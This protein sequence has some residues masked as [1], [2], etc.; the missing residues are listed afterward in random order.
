[1]L[2]SMPKI[3]MT[4][5]GVAGRTLA[6]SIVR[7]S[8]GFVL[9]S[10]AVQVGGHVGGMRFAIDFPSI[11]TFVGLIVLLLGLA[12]GRRQANRGS[13]TMRFAALAEERSIER[14]RIATRARAALHDTVLNDLHA[15]TLSDVGTLT[16]AHRA[17]LARDIA[18]LT[19]PALLLNEATLRARAGGDAVLSSGLGPVIR[20]ARQRGLVVEISGDPQILAQLEPGVVSEVVKAVDQAL[21]NV[22][23]HANVNEAEVAIVAGVDTVNVVV[24]DAGTGFD[25]SAV[26]AQRMGLRVSISQRVESV[27]GTVR[28]WST[29]GSGTAVLLSVPLATPGA[30]T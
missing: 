23:K 10:V 25:A 8:L 4:V 20:S 24:T 30:V 22:S 29:P 27:G 5:V 28:V 6:S 17:F 18:S 1:M 12:A 26:D 14:S 3:A 7:C 21:V 13:D 19:H 2:L 16:D 9:A 11:A 15:L